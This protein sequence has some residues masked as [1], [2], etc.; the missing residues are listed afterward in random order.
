MTTNNNSSQELNKLWKGFNEVEKK[1]V[2]Y[3]LYVP[4]PVLI[5]TLSNL[6][7]ATAFQV[8]N[9]MEKLKRKKIVLEKKGY[10]KGAY[11]LGKTGIKEFVEEFSLQA[12]SLDAARKLIDFYRQT[13]G[14]DENKSLIL[15]DLYLKTGDIGEGLEYIKDAADFFAGTIKEKALVYYKIL[16]DFFKNNAPTEKNADIFID[17]VLKT[18]AAMIRVIPDRSK[19]ILL[20]KAEETAKRFNRL[21]YLAI[22]KIA[23]AQEL[24]QL[25]N[26]KK[27]LRC[28]TEFCKLIKGVQDADLLRTSTYWLCWYLFLQGKWLEL[29][30]IYEDSVK[31]LEEFGNDD[32][33]LGAALLVG[34]CCAICGRISRGIGIIDA[35]R[36]KA[37]LLDNKTIA[38]L[39]D[40]MTVLFLFEIRKVSNA[41]IF[42]DRLESFPENNET[43]VLKRELCE[44]RIYILC[45]KGDYEGAFEL[46]KQAISLGSTLKSDF[47]FTPWTFEYLAIFE[48]HGFIHEEVNYD[49]EIKRLLTWGDIRVKG[50]ALRYRALRN[51]ERNQSPSGIL[52]DLKKSEQYLKE[53]GAEVELARTHIA[54][55]RFFLKRDGVKAARPYLEKAWVF[56][57]AVDKGLFPNDLLAIMPQEQKVEFMM[58]RMIQIN[59]SLGTI[60]DNS[61]FL[62]RVIN[63]AMD[64]TMAT[65]GAFFVREPEGELKIIASRNIDPLLFNADK[66]KPVRNILQEATK[67]GGEFTLSSTQNEKKSKIQENL[68]EAGISSI[69]YM[70]ASLGEQTHGYLYLDNILGGD[71][72]R[73]NYLP[74]VR[75]LCNLIA[76]GLFNIGMYEEMRG[77]KDRFE[78]EAGFYKREMGV[79]TPVEMIVGESEGIKKVMAQVRQVAPMDT[80]VIVLGETGV[81]KELVAKAI[82]NLS[83]RKEG[84]FIPV[85]LAALPQELVASEL[86]GHERGAFTGANERHK[87]RFELADGGTIFLDEIGDLPLAVQVKLLRVLQE[88]IFERLGSTKPIHSNFRVVAATNKNLFAEVEKGNFRQDLYYRLSAFPIHVPPLRER[89]EDIPLIARYFLDAFSKKMGKTIRRI[90]DNELKK[91]VTYNWPGNVRELKHFIERSIILSDKHGI[92]FSGLEHQSGMNIDEDIGY[93]GLADF[94]RKYIEKVLIHTGWKVSGPYGA[95]KILK[96]K[97]TTLICR[98]KKLGIKKPPPEVF[99]KE[100]Q[101]KKKD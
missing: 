79:A 16:L 5:D 63:V 76:V 67:E 22:I 82:H 90:P 18:I 97:S 7:G 10:G 26:R 69:I 54:L 47:H 68:R 84:P 51:M 81:G 86:F 1:I 32:T 25:G 24:F 88:G 70:P 91:L 27:S 74:Y 6:S 15:A 3:L 55:G 94:E 40:F 23:L 71:L 34:Y 35:V 38:S 100:L 65:R 8:L 33:S 99:S 52:M 83:V 28:F 75:L 20:E 21:N 60:Q 4:S 30:R 80:S 42:L 45:T 44:C 29:V 62:E 37:N 89:K 77:L 56:F 96:L 46:Y 13:N 19:V 53:A 101:K 48:S 41:E 50:V 78:E 49:S 31:S 85:N 72:F 43:R 2:L 11:F 12:E 59:E 98:M 93:M 64:F 17:S 73:E 14:K 58:D 36:A 39:A 92:N 95:A 66:F 57:A 9:V 87:G 61:S